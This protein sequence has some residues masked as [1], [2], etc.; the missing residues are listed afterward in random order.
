M[1]HE[2]LAIIRLRSNTGI[3]ADTVEMQFAFQNCSENGGSGGSAVTA[4]DLFL[5]NGYAGAELSSFLAGSLDH[6]SLPEID[7]YD[8][9]GVLHG[10]H[11]GSPVATGHLGTGLVVPSV[12]T[13]LPLQAAIGLSYHADLTGLPEFGATVTD[14]PTDERAID[15]GAPATHTG[16]SRPKASRRGRI[17]FGP[18]NEAAMESDTLRIRKPDPAFVAC[19]TGAMADLAHNTAGW[20][21]WSRRNGEFHPVT[22]GWIADETDVVRRRRLKA[23]TRTLWAA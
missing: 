17:L 11:R 10:G 3:P 14:I 6:V 19:A 12:D 21:V 23:T 13:D 15:E 1:A 18:L 20:S 9:S 2:A 8:V 22:G 4:I 7:V 5:R 16:V